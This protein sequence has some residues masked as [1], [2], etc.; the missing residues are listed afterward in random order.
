MLVMTLSNATQSHID[1][2]VQKDVRPLTDVGQ[3]ITI[4]YWIMD[5]DMKY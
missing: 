2:L 5:M 4:Y 1:C 3:D